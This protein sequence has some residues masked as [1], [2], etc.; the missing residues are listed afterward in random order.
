MVLYKGNVKLEDLTKLDL[1]SYEESFSWL[2]DDQG[3][4]ID[5][6]KKLNMENG[7]K[8]FGKY[9]EDKYGLDKEGFSEVKLSEF[10]TLFT[11]NNKDVTVLELFNHVNKL[12][13][14]DKDSFYKIIRE[15][16]SVAPTDQVDTPNQIQSFL[17]ILNSPR[18]LGDYGDTTF[19]D[20]AVGLRNFNWDLVFSSAHLTLNV[21][22]A[23]SLG[24][25]YSLVMR[26]FSLGK[27]QVYYRPYPSNLTGVNLQRAQAIR[28][29]NLMLF[30]VIGAPII[31]FSVKSAG[32][33]AKDI[34]TIDALN[35]SG[36][37][38][39]K[40]SNVL[41]SGLFLFISQIK[42]PKW[43]KFLALIL[44]LSL[45]ILK[46]ISSVFGVISYLNYLK[47]FVIIY[48]I[49]VIFY[50]IFYLYL[51]YL[52]T[53]KNVNLSEILPESILKWLREFEDSCKD[54]YF[55]QEIK[56]TCYIEISIYIGIII[57]ISIL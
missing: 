39:N 33:L 55:V 30:S 2:V 28:N 19:N 16:T 6:N 9:L 11:E 40:N 29:R 52:F 24:I 32:L 23:I 43:L 14:Q 54:K 18:P 42:L 49:F 31:L 36:T 8:L 50:Q 41:N 44:I 46:G 7:V 45:L 35:T 17:D 57:F 13:S 48:S 10:L 1:S 27:K 34:F 20:V 21:F 22:P 4:P 37:D 47:L 53:I 26:T 15:V 3:R 5:F 56:T 12:Y 38:T 51:I 25:G